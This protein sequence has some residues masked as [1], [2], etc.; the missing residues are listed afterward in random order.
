MA[1]NK[2]IVGFIGVILIL[3]VVSGVI[4]FCTWNIG[5]MTIYEDMGGGTQIGREVM[6]RNGCTGNIW[7]FVFIGLA[8]I[9]IIYAVIPVKK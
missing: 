4:P 6:Y 5:T 8:V 3:L 1:Q 2:A 7:A 9:C